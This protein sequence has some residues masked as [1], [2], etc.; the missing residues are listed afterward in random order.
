LNYLLL[1]IATLI[2]YIGLNQ[3]LL[4]STELHCNAGIEKACKEVN[5]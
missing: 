3:S 5:K 4:K 2:F 1:L